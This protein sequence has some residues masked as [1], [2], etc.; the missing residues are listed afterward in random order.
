MAGER[1]PGPPPEQ[2]GDKG[3]RPWWRDW[4]GQPDWV[5]RSEASLAHGGPLDERWV[6]LIRGGLVLIVVLG[7]LAVVAG[8]WVPAA[9]SVVMVLLRLRSLRPEH[10]RQVFGL[11]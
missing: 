2:A 6:R 9:L 5:R 7:V 10:R 4:Y 8:Y 11:R 1:Y 3:G